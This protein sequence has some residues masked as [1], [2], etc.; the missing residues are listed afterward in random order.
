MSE[1]RKIYDITFKKM[2]R[3]S[4]RMLIRFVNKVFEKNFPLDSEVKFLPTVKTKKMKYLKRIFTLKS[5]GKDFRLR[6]SHT[7]MT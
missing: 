2:F 1:S 5:A 4:G 7:G 6:R 3:L